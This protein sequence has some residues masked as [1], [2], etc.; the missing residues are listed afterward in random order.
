MKKAKLL[1]L[2]VFAALCLMLPASSVM[3]AKKFSKNYVGGS[4]YETM[5]INKTYTLKLESKCKLTVSTRN[6]FR[7][8][9]GAVVP[10]IE[11]RVRSS[12]GRVY[13]DATRL[14]KEGAYQRTMTVPAGVYYINARGDAGYQILIDGTYIPTLSKTSLSL[15]KGFSSQLKLN[16]TD[17]KRTWTS[18]NKSIAVVDAKGKVTGKANGKCSIVCRLS[19]GTKLTCA[20]TV[21]NPLV[22]KIAY[23]SDTS[24]YNE[25]GIKFTNNTNKKITYI[26][27]L[28]AQYDNRGYRLSSP[29]DWYYVN[30][31][32]PANS[33]DTWEFWVNDD[34]KKVALTLKAIYFAD[35]SVITY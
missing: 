23:I 34:T 17:A 7:S 6:L 5:Q 13:Y 18:S 16:G 21:K 26:K 10:V 31:D 11:V 19:D 8:N 30:D 25:V 2:V 27:L 33:S 15:A 24:I 35:G 9:L 32:L 22:M 20:V 1:I 4:K 14:A 3:A 28:I 12:A 29:Y